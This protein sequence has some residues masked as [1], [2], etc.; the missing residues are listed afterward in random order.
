MNYHQTP[1]EIIAN[2]DAEQRILWNHIFLQFGEKIGLRQYFY[3]GV[4][5]GSEISIYDANKIYIALSIVAAG[6]S[7]AGTNRCYFT[8]FD[9][10]N[11][12]SMYAND[13][14]VLF[15]ATTAAV[16]YVHNSVELKNCY[17]SRLS[18]SQYSNIKFI[19]YRLSI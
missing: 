5:L 6:I 12:V 1:A 14:S 11:N 16:N 9:E 8:T 7:A 4:F 15:N 13:N 18:V 10:A 3:Q 17:F 2:A 19:G